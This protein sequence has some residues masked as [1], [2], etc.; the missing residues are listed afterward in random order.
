ML[1]RR[2]LLAGSTATLAGLAFRSQPAQE[3]PPRKTFRIALMTDSHLPGEK[4]HDRLPNDKLRHQQR[5]RTAF[6]R[7]NA[8]KPELIVFGGDNIF[9]VDQGNSEENART[10]F[11]NWQGIVKERAA[12]PTVSVIGNHDIWK[13]QGE[14][15]KDNKALAVEHFGMPNRFYAKDISGWRFLMLDVFHADGCHIDPEQRSWMEGQIK[16]FSGPVCLVSHAPILSVSCIIDGNAFKGAKEMFDLFRKNE[17]VKLCLSGHQ[18]HVDR[19]DYAGVSYICGGAV[20]GAWWEGDYFGFP[21]AWVS[22]EL[23]PDGVIE[24]EVM[25]YEKQ[26]E[27]VV[28]RF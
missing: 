28:V 24:H 3:T 8:M 10:Q 4:T 6:D 12:C 19:C 27:E 16:E 5:I 20:S 18:H 15:P 17:N 11:R 22:L 13:P 7:V 14:K 1:T 2:E 26:P 9:A 25:F 21:P 23:M